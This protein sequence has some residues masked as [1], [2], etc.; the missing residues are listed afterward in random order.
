MVYDRDNGM[1]N[2][3]I[4]FVDAYFVGDLDSVGSTIGY[5]FTLVGGH[6]T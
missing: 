4:G 6:V 5:V 2:I 1:E 3:L